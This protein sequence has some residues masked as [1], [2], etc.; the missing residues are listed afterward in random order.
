[1][2]FTSGSR[3]F[4]CEICGQKVTV[5]RVGSKRREFVACDVETFYVNVGSGQATRESGRSVYHSRVCPPA[6]VAVS[7]PGD[8]K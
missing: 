6:D 7:T 3:S 2:G 5:A 4:V 1:M 8:P